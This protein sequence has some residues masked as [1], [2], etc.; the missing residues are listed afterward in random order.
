MNFHCSQEV[1]DIDGNKLLMT[2]DFYNQLVTQSDEQSTTN[3]P[4]ENTEQTINEV[5][6]IQSN[7][8]SNATNCTVDIDNPILNLIIT[9]QENLAKRM[10]IMEKGVR[11][12][13][14]QLINLSAWLKNNSNSRPNSAMSTLSSTSN[15]SEVPVATQISFKLINDEKDLNEFEEII[16][17]S[18]DR[19]VFCN[20]FLKQISGI[21]TDRVDE[22]KSIRTIALSLDRIM[23]SE[24]FW[25]KTAWTGGRKIDGGSKKF[26]FATHTTF[27]GFFNDI[28]HKIC[29][30]QM[31]QIEFAEFVKG[32]TRNSGYVRAT[33]RLPAARSMGR[34]GKRKHG[35]GDSKNDE[36]MNQIN[37][38]PEQSTSAADTATPQQT[39]TVTI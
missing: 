24:T 17:N 32:R 39:S 23:L 20:Y 27:M 18:N 35:D 25:S 5:P 7:E 14:S 36:S 15:L 26:V 2:D 22:T 1:V 21:K 10:L 8:Y 12:I 13:S 4:T 11:E 28:I 38:Q 37:P 34:L 19:S 31:S 33:S 3:P 16:K 29:G 30:S 6:S 9:N